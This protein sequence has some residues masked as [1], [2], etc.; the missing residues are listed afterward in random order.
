MI[1]FNV[2]GKTETNFIDTGLMKMG[3][4]ALFN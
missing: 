2:S 4:V 3:S 1:I